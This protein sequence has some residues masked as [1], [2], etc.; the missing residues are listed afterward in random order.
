MEFYISLCKFYRAARYFYRRID[1]NG[2]PAKN[3][4]RRANIICPVDDLYYAG[5]VNFTMLAFLSEAFSK[6]RNTRSSGQENNFLVR[7]CVCVFFF[8]F[9]NS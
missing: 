2:E 7:F 9:I 6:F 5:I 1:F 3:I 4:V 8:N